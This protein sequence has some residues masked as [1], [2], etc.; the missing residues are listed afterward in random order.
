M[1][2]PDE[3]ILA[4]PNG[5]GGLR[6][7]LTHAGVRGCPD[8]C[9]RDPELDSNGNWPRRLRRRSGSQARVAGTGRRY[10]SPVGSPVRVAGTETA[11]HPRAVA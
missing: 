6:L 10:G 11:A 7:R 9:I 1:A 3:T 4:S 5:D 2:K 8:T